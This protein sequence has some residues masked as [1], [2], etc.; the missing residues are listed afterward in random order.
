MSQLPIDR[1]TAEE[2]HRDQLA[3]AGTPNVVHA[4]RNVVG[5]LNR[6]SPWNDLWGDDKP[7]NGMTLTDVTMPF[8]AWLAVAFKATA[9]FVIASLVIVGPLALIAW[10]LLT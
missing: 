10:K 4:D 6:T 1:R 9:A 2:V 3:G 8:E 5:A 7:K